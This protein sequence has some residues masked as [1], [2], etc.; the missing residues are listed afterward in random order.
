LSGQIR[1]AA[2]FDRSE[3]WQRDAAED[4]TE[5]WSDSSRLPW[6]QARNSPIAWRARG[7]GILKNKEHAELDV[8]V[9]GIFEDRV[10]ALQEAQK[11]PAA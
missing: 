4:P 7:L 9:E 10:G 3:F 6:D 11:S 5:R 1:R 8:N 2:R